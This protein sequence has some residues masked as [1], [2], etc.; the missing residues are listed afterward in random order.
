M[1]V[2]VLLV[3][4]A[5]PGGRGTELVS[6]ARR[7]AMVAPLLLAV[8]ATGEQVSA[9]PLPF[10]AHGHNASS[11]GNSA[12]AGRL[13]AAPTWELVSR[14]PQARLGLTSSYDEVRRTYTRVH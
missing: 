4:G 12:A 7:M 10:H 11:R 8:L 6:M 3:Q 9:A 2:A 5:G 1:R 14:M 13:G